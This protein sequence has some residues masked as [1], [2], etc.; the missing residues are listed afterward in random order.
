MD[1]LRLADSLDRS[2][3]QRV[4]SI[5][6]HVRGGVVVIEVLAAADADLDLWA[7]ERVAQV[8]RDVYQMPLE[9]KTAR[10]GA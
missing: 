3:S 2:H 9:L 6:C 7:A 4:E 8:F 1:G 5:E 10:S